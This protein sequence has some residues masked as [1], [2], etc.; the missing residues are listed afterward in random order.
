MK[1]LRP[2]LD[3]RMPSA[4]A[5]AARHAKRNNGPNNPK[6]VRMRLRLLL[7][8]L[9]GVRRGLRETPLSRTLL[10]VFALSMTRQ[11]QRDRW[12]LSF[13]LQTAARMRPSGSKGDLVARDSYS[14]A[15]Q[16]NP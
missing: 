16:T 2:R 1:G 8:K 5:G 15:L 7:S 6:R 12:F 13:C 9:G 10:R 3:G 14:A 11:F 4:S